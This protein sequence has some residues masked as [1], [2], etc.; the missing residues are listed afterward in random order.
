MG[1]GLINIISHASS[2]LYLTGSPQITFYKMV[3]RRYT[4]FAM[5][6]V[7]LDFDDRLKFNHESELIPSRI[8]D[9]IHKGYLH[10][11]IPSMSVSH[12]DVGVD[13]SGIN[14]SYSDKSTISDFNLIKTTYM[15][16][17]VQLYVLVFR[18]TNALNVD[19]AGILKD[20]TNYMVMNNRIQTLK[21]YDALLTKTMD[22]LI[23]QNNPMASIL[24]YR[25]SDLWYI[26]NNLDTNTLYRIAQQTIDTTLYPEGTEAYIMQINQLMKNDV[27]VIITRGLENCKKVQS[28][29]FEQ[30]KQ[31]KQMVSNDTNRNIRFA[32]VRNLGHSIIE[33]IDVY[34]GGKRIDRHVGQWIAIWHQ[35]TYK[36][37]QLETYNRMIGNVSQLTHF[38]REEKPSYDLYIPLSFWFN[39]FNGLSFPLVAMQYND[40]RF[41][42]RLRRIEE[43]SY[44]ERIYK[45]NFEGVTKILT[46]GLIDFYMN[47]SENKGQINITDIELI[48]TIRLDDIWRDKGK[49]LQGHMYLDYVYLENAERRKFAQSGHE[50]LIETIQ[51]T[52]YERISEQAFNLDIEFVNPSKEIIWISSK[53][54][55]RQNPYG[56]NVCRWEDF[57]TGFGKVNP[58]IDAKLSFNN[59]T[60]IP[61]QVGE[62]FD[63][64]QP[65]QY[66]HISPNKGICMYS[67]CIDPLSHQPTGSCNFSKLT[68]VILSLNLRNELFE[69]TDEQIYPFDL[70]LDFTLTIPQN[71]VEEFLLSINIGRMKKIVSDLTLIENSLGPVK[72]ELLESYRQTLSTLEQME[73]KQTNEIPM[74]QYR[75]LIFISEARI[76]A[77]D[78]GMNI[79]RIIGGYGGTAYSGNS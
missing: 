54:I 25:M 73:D 40:I 68:N 47:R 17:L 55:F 8:G 10:I 32:W 65:W 67:F 2:D 22:D 23:I 1:G 28:Y 75:L 60:R 9:L 30:Y 43:V 21:Q 33:Y 6:S 59:Y 44:I 58:V 46:A 14:F 20:C 26:L 56:Y 39:K 71:D 45:V 31:Y 13:L 42:V 3:Y 50:Y 76:T 61:K 38:D 29:Y 62:Y 49:E 12:T 79:L 19:Y 37:D 74:S 48:Q 35:L 70:D 4:N 57:T 66:H 27:L 18:A 51:Y 7:S 41:N 34:I 16:I 77:F 24:D 15:E 64:Y 52:D 53:N 78:L 63:T 69:Y 36:Y 72:K 5:E 11:K